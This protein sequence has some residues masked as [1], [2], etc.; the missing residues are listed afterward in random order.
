MVV[1]ED[2]PMMELFRKS[3]D[4]SRETLVKVEVCEEWHWLPCPKPAFASSS[5]SWY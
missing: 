2:I 3:V 1:Q 4:A 5:T